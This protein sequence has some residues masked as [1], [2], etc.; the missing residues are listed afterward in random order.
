VEGAGKQAAGPKAFVSG[1]L[2]VHYIPKEKHSVQPA[3]IWP[4]N[5]LLL[6]GGHVELE[7]NDVR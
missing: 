6:G 7:K 4:S 3:G 2:S 1:L 5:A